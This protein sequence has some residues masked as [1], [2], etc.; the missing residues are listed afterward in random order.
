[1]ISRR[2]RSYSGRSNDENLRAI[3]SLQNRFRM[4]HYQKKLKR[5]CLIL[6]FPMGYVRSQNVSSDRDYSAQFLE[7]SG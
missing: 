4:T 7:M 1:M 6:L 3:T 2:A 5:A